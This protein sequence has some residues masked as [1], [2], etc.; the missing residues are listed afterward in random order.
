MSKI[1]FENTV[2][3]RLSEIDTKVLQ[4]NRNKIRLLFEALH[5]R[6]NPAGWEEMLDWDLIIVS[7]PDR[8]MA[9]QLNNLVAFV[10]NVKFMAEP[11]KPLFTLSPGMKG[12]RIWKE[13]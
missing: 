9:R 10:P 5:I 3:K 8:G 2:L 13:R 1:I 12:R 4:L 7:V 6:P 11:D